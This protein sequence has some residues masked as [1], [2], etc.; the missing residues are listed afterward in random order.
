MLESCTNENS[1]RRNSPHCQMQSAR[2]R[3]GSNKHA[4]LHMTPPVICLS[5]GVMLRQIAVSMLPQVRRLATLDREH[6][7]QCRVSGDS[8]CTESAAGIVNFLQEPD[9]EPTST[10]D[11]AQSS[12][13]GKVLCQQGS[14]PHLV[15]TH[16]LM[17][18][19]RSCCSEQCGLDIAPISSVNSRIYKRNI[20]PGLWSLSLS[21]T[22]ENQSKHFWF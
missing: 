2:P 8:R 18:F 12:V 20:S 6:S 10:P 9:V 19:P 13:R 11:P 5:S 21:I 1:Q 16:R 22:A 3:R 7:V 14:S 4:N 15:G 17:S